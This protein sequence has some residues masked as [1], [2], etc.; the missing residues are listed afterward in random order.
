MKICTCIVYLFLTQ[1]Y[2]LI[3][4]PCGSSIFGAKMKYMYDHVTSAKVVPNKSCHAMIYYFDVSPSTLKDLSSQINIL[5]QMGCKVPLMRD[6]VAG[7]GLT[8]RLFWLSDIVVTNYFYKTAFAN[9]CWDVEP[10]MRVVVC[11]SVSANMVKLPIRYTDVSFER[12]CKV[13]EDR[14][15]KVIQRKTSEYDAYISE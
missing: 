9:N 11:P 14:D 12:K 4:F 10:Y 13:Q 2:L 5:K 1:K 3:S 6:S 15:H 7:M 8:R